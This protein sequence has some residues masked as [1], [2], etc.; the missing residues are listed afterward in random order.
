MRLKHEQIIERLLEASTD[1][2][3]LGWET[4]GVKYDVGWCCIWLLSEV[5]TTR[6][7]SGCVQPAANFN[8][9]KDEYSPSTRGTLCYK[10]AETNSRAKFGE[11]TVARAPRRPKW[12]PHYTRSAQPNS[13]RAQACS[14]F[15]RALLTLCLGSAHARL[16]YAHS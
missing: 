2:K 14:G 8:V 5:T 15:T 10:G 13:G 16:R 1:I 12:V 9:I 11:E 6:S 3:A 7:C 4:L